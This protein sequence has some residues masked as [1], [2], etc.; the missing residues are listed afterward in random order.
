MKKICIIAL[1]LLLF[2]GQKLWAISDFS[3]ISGTT[4]TIHNTEEMTLLAQNVNG[5]NTY[6]GYTFLLARDLVYDIN[7]ANRYTPIGNSNSK[8]F[9]GTF[10]GQNHTIS[11]INISADGRQGLFG[12]VSGGTIKNLKLTSSTINCTSNSYAGGIIACVDNGVTIENCHVSGSVTIESGNSS[13]GI[14]GKTD[15][16]DVSIKGCSSGATVS[17]RSSN[18]CVGGIIG[19]CGNEGNGSYSTFVNIAGC[20][21]YGTSLTGSMEMTGGIVGYYYT[22]YGSIEEQ[23]RVN[24]SDNFYTYSDVSV[25]GVGKWKKSN[26]NYTD[27]TNLFDITE[28]KGAI[29]VRSVTTQADI[30][31][32]EGLRNDVSYTSDIAFHN[33]GVKYTGSSYSHVLALEDNADNTSVI[34]QY[35]GQT[36]DVK[37]RGRRLYKDDSWNTICLPFNLTSYTGTVFE[38]VT[39]CTCEIREMDTDPKRAY[40]LKDKTTNQYDY[41]VPYKTGVNEKDGKRCLYLFFKDD[42]LDLTAGKPFIVKWYNPEDNNQTTATSFD[43]IFNPIFD[44]VTI[45]SGSPVTVT[46]QDGTVSFKSIY[47]PESFD[48]ADRSILFVGAANTLYYPSGAGTVSLNSFRAYFQLN[49]VQMSESSSGSSTDDDDDYFPGPGNVKVFVFDIEEGDA[50]G[51]GIVRSKTED[52]RCDVWYSLDGKRLNGTPAQKGIYIHNGRKEVLK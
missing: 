15:L 12:S 11:G 49:G 13:G 39:G 7:A 48:E 8:Y 22:T 32:M 36:F 3:D 23:S 44:N 25:K 35:A 21:Y 47:A 6:N 2:S 29:R 50:S 40:Y 46:S 51:I 14:V 20:L 42:N 31:D 41:S 17:T 28:N 16:G 34:A 9:A 5:G 10:D 52:G 18:A 24:L 26:S 33:R 43:P 1:T 4:I 30:D 45:V 19:Q 27:E 37:L 38:S